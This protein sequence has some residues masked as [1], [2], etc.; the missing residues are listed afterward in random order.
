[1]DVLPL[2]D[3]EAFL[4]EAAPLLLEDE[5]RHNLILG[6][7][8]TVRSAPAVYPERVE[9]VPR[10][11]GASREATEADRDLLLDWMLAFA[12]E[13]LHGSET[14]DELERMLD[15][16]LTAD[17]AGFVLWEDG[18]KPVS[19]SGYGG[20]TPNGIRVGPVYTPPELR[21]RG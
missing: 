15:Y 3:P 4:A 21:G 8:E 11:G 19:F 10:P 2:D 18:G 12:V 9:P 14:D 7:A 17:T 16:R 5:A 6:I 1:M 13:A 20:Q